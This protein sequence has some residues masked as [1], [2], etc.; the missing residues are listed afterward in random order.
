MAELNPA[1]A[2]ENAGATHHA[3][4][5]RMFMSALA[6]R[7]EGVVE[8]GGLLVAQRGAGANMSV[9]IAVGSCLVFGDENAQ[10]GMYGCVNDAIKNVV[11]AAADPTNPRRDLIIARVKDAFYS[12]ATNAWSLE[13]ITG[14]AAGSPVDPAMVNNAICLARVSVGAAAASIVNANIADLRPF[15]PVASLLFNSARRPGV[16]YGPY[17]QEPAFKPTPFNGLPGYELDTNLAYVYNGTAWVCVTPQ[18]NTVA[19]S[20]V[21]G[22]A[23]AYVDLATVG[24]AVTVQTGTKALIT[25]STAFN[26]TQNPLVNIGVAVSGATTLA[27][28]DANSVG[29]FNITALNNG[30]A[31]RTFLLTGLTPGVNVFTMKYKSSTAAA[32]TAF[33]DRDITVV[34]LP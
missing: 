26:S 18:S 8:P 5:S 22:S 33:L 10:Q 17:S 29:P 31:M 28:S 24:P 21:I 25:L 32:S 34:G 14:V 12:G 20:Q 30:T 15:A 13:V 3:N 19:T 23:A 27:A 11:I 1:W 4:V 7:A 2:L 16:L 6:E 9:D